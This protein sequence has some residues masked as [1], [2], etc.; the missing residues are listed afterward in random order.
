MRPLRVGESLDGALK[1][2]RAR[3]GPLLALAAIFALPVGIIEILLSRSMLESLASAPFFEAEDRLRQLQYVDWGSTAVQWLILTPLLTGASVRIIASTYLGTK[4]GV[5]EAL[6]F[7]LRRLPSLLW[8]VILTSLILGA[9]I[10]VPVLIAVA[11][12]GGLGSAGS[13]GEALGVVVLVF[14]IA[15]VPI[16]WLYVLL[17]FPSEVVVVENT[18]GTKA[19]RR[20]MALA[21]GHAGRVFWTMFCANLLVAGIAFVIGLVGVSMFMQA[22][23]P[24]AII[25]GFTIMG[26]LTLLLSTLTQP[27]LTSVIVL[28]YFDLRIRKEG[29]DLA[30]M[31]QEIG[32]PPA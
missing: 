25:G 4:V 29:F 23:S 10:L 16:I 22:T 8:V 32:Q 12:G 26:V 31:A 11:A 5:G 24:E 30:V 17:L 21:R 3:F 19:I 13:P 9:A 20:S 1:L 18:R 14:V 28:L 6:G 7:A 2:Y 27:F 15:I